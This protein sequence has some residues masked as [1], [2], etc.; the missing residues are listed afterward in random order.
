[1]SKEIVE[2]FSIFAGSDGGI[3]SWLLAESDSRIFERLA[4]LT[5]EPL[6]RAQLNQLLLL[7]HEAPLSQGFYK[8]Y[9][10]HVPATHL[11]PYRVESL[12][13]YAPDYADRQEIASLEH[14]RWGLYRFYVDALLYFGNV[15]QA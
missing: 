8:Y 4:L 13:G 10:M 1:M 2:R 15:R 9:W 7:G 11:H 14:L 12:E 3:E 5:S 6:G